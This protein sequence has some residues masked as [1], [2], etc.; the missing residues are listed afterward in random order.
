MI[1]ATATKSEGDAIMRFILE[2]DTALYLGVRCDGRYL[3]FN[4]IPRD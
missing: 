3:I 2:F 1:L 4:L